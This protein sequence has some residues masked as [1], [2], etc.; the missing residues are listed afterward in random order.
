MR[1]YL[2]FYP[3]DNELKFER[4]TFDAMT[5]EEAWNELQKLEGAR[6]YDM[7]RSDRNGQMLDMGDFVEDYNDE[8]LDGGWWS[9]V[10]ALPEEQEEVKE[11]D[12]PREFKKSERVCYEDKCGVPHKAMVSCDQQARCEDDEVE[13]F[14]FHDEE[15][16]DSQGIE[17]KFVKAKGVYQLS[18]DR[19]SCPKCG[20]PLCDEHLP[21][22]DYP[23]YCPWCQE[24]FYGIEVQ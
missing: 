11:L 16:D 18:E 5:D 1:K 15:D 23:Y 2:V 21:H 13:V 7:T 22:M 10:L 6:V 14:I 4:H 9:I 19:K 24:N 3:V 17:L 12:Y 8:E 20:E